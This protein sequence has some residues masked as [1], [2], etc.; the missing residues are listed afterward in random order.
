MT[1]GTGVQRRASN[2]AI[3]ELCRLRASK[4]SQARIES[5]RR[6]AFTELSP[7]SCPE[8]GH[9]YRF[10][11]KALAAVLTLSLFTCPCDRT[12]T[13]ILLY[14]RLPHLLDR[15][16]ALY[17][18]YYESSTITSFDP[19]ARARATLSDNK[20]ATHDPAVSERLDHRSIPRDPI[21][22][23]ARRTRGINLVNSHSRVPQDV[24]RAASHDKLYENENRCAL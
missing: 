22:D 18:G 4:Q 13:T 9:S 3:N 19:I 15:P 12:Q 23:I 16:D 21:S 6:Q 14:I 2:H 10:T 5:R 17:P 7:N 8:G 24:Y 20:E 1:W 11:T